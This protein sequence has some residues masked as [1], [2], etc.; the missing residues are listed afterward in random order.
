MRQSAGSLG[1]EQSKLPKRGPLSIAKDRNLMLASRLRYTYRARDLVVADKIPQER[2]QHDPML[3]RRFVLAA[4][5]HWMGRY[6]PSVSVSDQGLLKASSRLETYKYRCDTTTNGSDEVR[7]ENVLDIP[8]PPC[9]APFVQVSSEEVLHLSCFS[10]QIPPWCLSSMA[11]PP[12][13]PTASL[14]PGQRDLSASVV[15]ESS[16]SKIHVCSHIMM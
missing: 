8:C 3:G 10:Q 7:P 2:C 5:M 4:W 12:H 1:D 11:H 15:S 13:T 9:W 14:C 16:M 6:M